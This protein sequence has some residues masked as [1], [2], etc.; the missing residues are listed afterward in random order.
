MKNIDT[1]VIA[2][3]GE[4]KRLDDYF[5]TINFPNTKTLLPVKGQPLLKYFIDMALSIG[6]KNI[7]L[8][9]SFYEDKILEFIDSFYK[10][11]NIIVVSGGEKGKRGGVSMVLSSI[12]DRLKN[13]F[14][15]SDGDILFEKNLLDDLFNRNE[16]DDILIKCII[17]PKDAAVSH[18]KFII[19]DGRLTDIKVHCENMVNRE[20]DGYCSLG[21]MTINNN[22]FNFMPD[23]KDANDLDIVIKNLFN[24]NPERV[25]FKIYGGEWLSIHTE[26][27]TDK[28][29]SGYY[30]SLLRSLK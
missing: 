2:V 11:K 30:N 4:S 9:A 13:P 5:K 28:I 25:G 23:Y 8:L 1:I 18:S 21:I 22:I 27:D 26:T 24:R 7:F 20:I 15:Y 3:G 16:M 29:E 14:V 10:D 6:F 12:A 17:S 19:S